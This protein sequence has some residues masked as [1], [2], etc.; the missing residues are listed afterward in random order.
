M[1]NGA[2]NFFTV[3]SS[4]PNRPNRFEETKSRYRSISWENYDERRKYLEIGKAKKGAKKIKIILKPINVIFS[5]HDDEWN[6][7]ATDG[8]GKFMQIRSLEKKKPPLSC[9]ND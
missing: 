5:A 9:R 3:S 6:D 8:N 1:L 4:N 7:E 2:F